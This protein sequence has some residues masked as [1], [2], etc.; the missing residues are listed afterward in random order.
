MTTLKITKSKLLRIKVRFWLDDHTGDFRDRV[1]L[2]LCDWV[3]RM[4]ATRQTYDNFYKAVELGVREMSTAEMP[5]VA[6]SLHDV[7]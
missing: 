2:S 3:L 4:L 5:R 1:A 6:E 7:P